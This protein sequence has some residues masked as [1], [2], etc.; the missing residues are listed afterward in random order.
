MTGEV[1]TL[2]GW[3]FDPS[4]PGTS[5]TV[6]VYV[7]GRINSPRFSWPIETGPTSIK[8]TASPGGTVCP[9]PSNSRSR[10]NTICVYGI[11][12]WGSNG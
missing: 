5:I 10:I 8:L 12:E 9:A 4:R 11:G 3:T 1:A 7:N 2:S 6:H